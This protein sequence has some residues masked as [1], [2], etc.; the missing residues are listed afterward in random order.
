MYISVFQTYV[1][2][3]TIANT[4]HRSISKCMF[5]CFTHKYKTS[6]LLIHTMGLKKY[7][8]VFHTYQ[9]Y[10]TCEVVCVDACTVLLY[11]K[12]CNVPS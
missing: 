6:Q 3:L 10:V 8:S 11:E 7:I 2:N 9:T 4:S 12:I 5:L 1:P